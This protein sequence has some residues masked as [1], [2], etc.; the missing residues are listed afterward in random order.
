MKTK[1]LCLN[2]KRLLLKKRLNIR[3]RVGDLQL[4]V[5]F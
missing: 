3:G 4:T 5:S 1:L 2:P